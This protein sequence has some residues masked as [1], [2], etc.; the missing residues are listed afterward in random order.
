MKSTTEKLFTSPDGRGFRYSP[1][2]LLLLG[3]GFMYLALNASY[4][5][6]LLFGRYTPRLVTYAEMPRFFVFSVIMVFTLGAGMA[7]WGW[8]RFR[9]HDG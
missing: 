3:A 9:R 2:V 6:E 8:R 7:W 4:T 5:G 1:F